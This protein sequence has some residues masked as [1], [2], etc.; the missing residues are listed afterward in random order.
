VGSH[1]KDRERW[2]TLFLAVMPVLHS[3]L[4]SW[5][6]QVTPSPTGLAPQVGR[7][8]V[9]SK[10]S[11]L[12][13]STGRRYRKIITILFRL[14]FAQNPGQERANGDRIRMLR[15]EYIL[16]DA[17]CLL[18]KGLCLHSTSEYLRNTSK[19]S[20]S[21][22]GSREATARMESSSETPRVS[23]SSGMASG[24]RK[25]HRRNTSAAVGLCCS[26]CWN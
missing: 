18:A 26:I 22:S 5:R 20:L 3:S 21:L 4:C 1:Y 17:E 16:T 15:P 10:P 19:A 23:S 7:K 11:P 8:I 9:R 14:S 13:S 25:A 24:A 12:S 6:S 2:Q